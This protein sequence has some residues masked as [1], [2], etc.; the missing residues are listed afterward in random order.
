MST[1][2][3]LSSI[4]HHAYLVSYGNLLLGPL[5]GDLQILFP[6][7]SETCL[8]YENGQCVP[9]EY[10]SR[11]E[12]RIT[13]VTRNTSAAL[14]LE[15]ARLA[16]SQASPA[17][18]VFAPIAAT[19]EKTLTFPRAVLLPGLEFLPSGITGH[20]AQLRFRCTVQPATGVLFTFA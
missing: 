6:G 18:L 19:Q 13:L 20:T 2:Y 5:A 1:A 11:T 10:F 8:L 15:A 3:D 17:S 9:A 7:E 4:K 14:T 12:A 16:E